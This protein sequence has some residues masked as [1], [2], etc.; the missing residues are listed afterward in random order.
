[1]RISGEPDFDR[2]FY[3]LCSVYYSHKDNGCWPDQEFDLEECRAKAKSDQIPIVGFVSKM[4]KPELDFD[5][6]WLIDL[7]YAE[8]DNNGGVMDGN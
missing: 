5:D 4:T 3:K 7:Q 1:M 8:V 6:S 2:I